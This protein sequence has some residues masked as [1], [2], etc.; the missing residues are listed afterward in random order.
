M[1]FRERFTGVIELCIVRVLQKPL[2]GHL[3]SSPVFN[4]LAVG[5]V[6]LSAGF[7]DLN[8]HLKLH[9]CCLLSI[10]ILAQGS[11]VLVFLLVIRVYVNRRG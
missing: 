10:A 3:V 7:T 8:F 11:S 9:I 5:I 1:R 6:V 4:Q 2:R